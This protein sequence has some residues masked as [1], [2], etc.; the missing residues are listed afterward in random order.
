M[1]RV[2]DE[3]LNGYA[4]LCGVNA[5]LVYLCLCR[6]ADRH[7]ESFPSIE[8]MSEKSGI[9]ESSV[10]RGISTL[11]EWNIIEK[12]RE[13]KGTGRWLNNRY[14]LLDKKVWKKKPQVTQTPGPQVT[15]TPI[16][17]SQ[18]PTK[19]THSKDTHKYDS[20][21]LESDYSESQD[22]EVVA[23][24]AEGNPLPP[25]KKST[26]KKSL[27]IK[28][29]REFIRQAEKDLGTRPAYTERGYYLILEAIN[30]HGLDEH[31]IR[32][33]LDDWFSLGKP[34]TELIHITRALSNNRINTWKV[35]NGIK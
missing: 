18:G 5:T 8:T 14:V 4:R 21:D 17:R 9:S 35:E 10:K 25:K 30:K 34:D 20:K 23:C 3:Y 31:Q 26:G 32:E 13:R 1:F 16:H 2:D 6:H 24:D 27:A 7:Q 15:G 11:I 29:Q 28:I 33:L 19:D 12:K 22:I